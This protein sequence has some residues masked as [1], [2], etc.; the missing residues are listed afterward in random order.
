MGYY[1]HYNISIFSGEKY[2]NYEP[3][4]EYLEKHKEDGWTYD[5]LYA[6]E[7]FGGDGEPCKWYDYHKDMNKFSLA[8]PDTLF[9][10]HREGEESGDIE[11]V[12]YK[13]GKSQVCK[14]R[15]VF[16]E[17]DERKMK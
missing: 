14:A 8:F 5:M 11:K 10:L 17:Y 2:P 9:E 16:E 4:V 12:Y 6:L 1:S 3:M 7:N 15:I 13:N